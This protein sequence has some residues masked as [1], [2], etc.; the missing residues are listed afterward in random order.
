MTTQATINEAAIERVRKLL[1]LA[2]DKRG[3][4]NEAANAASLAQK[5]MQ[6]LGIEVSVLEARGESK[7]GGERGKTKHDRAAMYDY[8]RNL[9]SE[10]A[11][12][13]FCRYSSVKVHEMSNGKMRFV[14][15]HQ[16]LG[17]KT[18]VLGATMLYDY[19]VDTMDRLL[20]YQGMDKRGKDALLWLGGCSERLIE[21]L[22]QSRRDAEAESQRRADEERTRARHPGAAPGTALVVLS[23]VYSSEDDFNADFINGREPGTTA[24]LRAEANARHA[25]YIAQRDAKVAELVAGGF[26]KAIAEMIAAGYDEEDARRI[27]AERTRPRTAKELGRERR[28]QARADERWEKHWA[29]QEAKRNTE[30]WRQGERAGSKIGLDKQVGGE[31]RRGIK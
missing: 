1:A 14:L 8:Q 31:Y 2:R 21:R 9:M 25:A 13:H 29:R 5:L 23:D 3:N 19:L 6:D 15:R 11:Q 26:A 7:A 17:R 18:N 16:L 28:E 22:R 20:P 27:H 30:A 10:I 4:E 24:R 12:G